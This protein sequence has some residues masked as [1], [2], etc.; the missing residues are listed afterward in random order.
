MEQSNF[1]QEYEE[2]FSVP[3]ETVGSNAGWLAFPLLIKPEAPFSRKEFQ[4]LLEK[5]LVQIINSFLQNNLKVLKNFNAIFNPQSLKKMIINNK[6]NLTLLVN[7]INS[8]YK[9]YFKI[10]NADLNRLNSLIKSLNIENTLKRGFVLI[11]D[12]K[13][14]FIKNS[15]VLKKNKNINI[16]FYD[17]EISAEIKLNK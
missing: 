14:E 3:V 7:S 1:F 4:I 5:N 6:K 11:T 17:D 2:F 16:K 15:E 12:K 9:S 8:N 10:K 13:K